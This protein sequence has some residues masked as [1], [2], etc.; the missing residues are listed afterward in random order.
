MTNNEAITAVCSAIVAG[1]GVLGA[2]IRWSAGI[3]R[4]VVLRAVKAIDASTDAWNKTGDALAENT[5]TLTRI[6][7]KLDVIKAV[8][9]AVEDVVDEV[10]GAHEPAPPT[11]PLR[12]TPRELPVETG[13]YP[14][15]R[16]KTEPGNR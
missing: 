16:M 5:K 7:A 2:A 12:R 15:R 14:P 8:E 10:S 4:G 6:E 9:N 11:A 3:L 13:Y 1:A